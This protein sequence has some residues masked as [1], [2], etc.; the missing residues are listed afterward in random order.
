MPFLFLSVSLS[1]CLSVKTVE[2][3]INL[4][5]HQWQFIAPDNVIKFQPTTWHSV[6]SGRDK[7]IMSSRPVFYSYVCTWWPKNWHTIFV[8]LNLTLSPSLM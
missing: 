2:C 5:F 8:R 3:I 4:N 6:Q 1:I 7:F